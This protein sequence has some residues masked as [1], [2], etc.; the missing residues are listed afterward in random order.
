MD[1][2]KADAAS[3][4][5][6]DTGSRHGKTGKHC[7]S[8]V[9]VTTHAS[10]AHKKGDKAA[11]MNLRPWTGKHKRSTQ[12]RDFKGDR[13]TESASQTSKETVTQEPP[14]KKKRLRHQS[15]TPAHTSGQGKPPHS[16]VTATQK[17]HKHGTPSADW[18]SDSA[19]E[20][21]FTPQ[22]F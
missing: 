10:L 14:A 8:S 2:N 17:L 7:T 13:L 22:G 3:L 5:N 4:H 16:T 9:A 18:S 20:T 15:P 21:E 11:D 6:T 12:P 19:A 1:N